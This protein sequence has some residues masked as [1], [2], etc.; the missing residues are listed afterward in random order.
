MTLITCVAG[1][2]CS[3]G[4][5]DGFTPEPGDLLFQ[6]G[7]TVG[8]G[9]ENAENGDGDDMSDAIAISTGG[10]KDISF[11][12]A[13]MV[14]AGPD[15]GVRVLEASG[16]HGVVFTPLDDF[17]ARS[18]KLDGRPVVAVGR[19]VGPDRERIVEAAV[20]RART[21]LGQPYDD[22]FMPSN[23]RMYC[24]ELIHESYLG[25]D[26]QIFS[27][28][29][30]NFRAPDGSMPAYWIDH[31]AALGE[32]IPEGVPGTN[33]DDM[34]RHPAITIVHRYHLP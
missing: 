15:G 25:P 18:S 27:P 9:S 14:V 30:M 13:A 20:E 2:G 34:S 4:A 7:A 16:R 12:H 32:P 22:S 1:A 6:C 11:T 28:A 19:L 8:R 29:P 24:T 5:G 23:G 21:F 33:P 3:G 17:L 31:F 10:T 26:G